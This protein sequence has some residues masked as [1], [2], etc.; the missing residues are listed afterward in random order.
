MMGYICDLSM[1]RQ[2]Q[3]NYKFQSSLTYTINSKSAYIR[4]VSPPPSKSTPK[5]VVER[6]GQL[7]DCPEN[8]RYPPIPLHNGQTGGHAMLFAR[9]QQALL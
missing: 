6:F 7:L 1:G 5:N 3:E 8:P 2:R 4:D 9:D